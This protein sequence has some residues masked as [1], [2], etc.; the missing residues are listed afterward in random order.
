MLAQN[1]SNRVPL[2]FEYTDDVDL[3]KKLSL[4]K[5]YYN[6]HRAHSALNGKSPYEALMEIMSCC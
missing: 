2:A 3:N 6:L 5:D 1:G 4:W